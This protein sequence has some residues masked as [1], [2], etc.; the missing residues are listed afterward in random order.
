MGE[1]FIGLSLSF[2]AAAAEIKSGNVELEWDVKLGSIAL[3]SEF[4]S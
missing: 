2:E 4:G 3:C 1:G